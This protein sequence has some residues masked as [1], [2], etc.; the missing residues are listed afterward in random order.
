LPED[1]EY[2]KPGRQMTVFFFMFNAAQWL[3]VTF[4]IQ[5]VFNLIKEVRF[6]LRK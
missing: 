1:K 5:K 3:V 2:A 4:E 6:V